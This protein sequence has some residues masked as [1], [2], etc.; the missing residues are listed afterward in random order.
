L[1]RGRGLLLAISGIHGPVLD[2]RDK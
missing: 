1:L 2:R